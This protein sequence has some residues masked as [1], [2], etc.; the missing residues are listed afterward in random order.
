MTKV[1]ILGSGGMAGHVV[2][3]TLKMSKQHFELMQ[4]RRDF[5][6]KDSFN[7]DL[8][9]L[10][11][12]SKIL[13]EYKPQ[14]VINCVG[15][16]NHFAEENPYD[17]IILNS[18][19]PHYIA[20]ECDILDSKLIHISTDCVFSGKNGPYSENS[21]K[22]GIGTYAT[23]KS[24]GEIN[25][26]RHITLR[27][28]II[29]PELKE[30]GI[31]L[32]HWYLK[33]R[34]EKIKGYKNVFWSGITTLQLAKTIEKIISK[35]DIKGLI[36][37]TNGVK[38]SKYELLNIFKTTFEDGRIIEK[39]YSYHSDKSLIVENQIFE[40]PSYEIMLNE[41]KEWMFDNAEL[42]TSQYP[43]IFFK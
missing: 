41:L 8:T 4:V 5:K 10:K 12:L 14:Y 15:I 28:S 40:I 16:L 43:E 18:A 24:L 35:K 26:G 21:K 34:G 31:G 23:T 30:N 13:K 17:A 29:G 37:V 2:Y 39:D 3:K 1:L 32:L 7:V 25:Y 19:L 27:T 11:E 22:D 33:N 36:H 6:A 9:N 20:R 42:Y 38:I